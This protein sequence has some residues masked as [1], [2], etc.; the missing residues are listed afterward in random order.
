[1]SSSA[2]LA[3]YRAALTAPGAVVPVLASAVGRFPIA[4]LPLATLLYVQRETGSFAAAGL[5]SAGQM[6]GVAAGSV[7]QGRVVDRLGPSRPLLTVVVLFV[8]AVTALVTAIETGQPLPV[9]VALATGAGIVRPALE[10]ASRSLWTVL[11]PAGSARSAALTYEAISLEVFFIL[12]PAIAAFLVAA[13]WPGL[14]LVVAGSAMALGAGAFALS[15]PARGIGRTPAHGG[16]S[17][18]GALGRPGMRTVAVASLGFGLVIGSVEVGLPAVTAAAGSPT[19]GGVLLSAWS[20]SSVLA[21]VLY[22]M[23]PWPRPLHLRMPALLGGFAVLVAAMA[24]V[25]PTGSM[26]VLVITMIVS[27]ALITP[28]VTGHSLAVDIAA[29]P[30]AAAEAFG[31]VITAATLGIATGQSSAG[32]VVEAFGPPAA[33]V[34]GGAAGVVLAMVLWLRRSTLLPQPVEA[35]APV[36]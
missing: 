9:V 29:P 5:V 3:D 19:L 28:Q 10:G 1:M 32:L 21:G 14:G 12:G 31:W 4:M 36:A 6:I 35:P 23:R 7:A 2:S 13:P 33:F 17:L 11:V 8:L 25:G 16:V 22:G 20:I 18:L 24:L 27:G 34:S 26:A 15:G 30:G